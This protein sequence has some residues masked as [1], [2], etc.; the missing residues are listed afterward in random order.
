M[1]FVSAIS[2]KETSFARSQCFSRKAYRLGEA[3]E[4]IAGP[5]RDCL[6]LVFQKIIAQH[7]PFGEPQYVDSALLGQSD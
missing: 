5:A 2:K 3:N 6:V 7:F 4:K 1:A